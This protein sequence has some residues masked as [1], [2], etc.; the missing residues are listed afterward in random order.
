MARGHLPEH[1]NQIDKRADGL[2]SIPP[3]RKE[4]LDRGKETLGD[5]EEDL[6]LGDEG[7]DA[8]LS[9]PQVSALHNL[10]APGSHAVGLLL[11]VCVGRVT[12]HLLLALY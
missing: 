5:G 4:D 9:A 6:G 8:G 3:W 12:N 11:T 1:G 2:M 7:L 10:L